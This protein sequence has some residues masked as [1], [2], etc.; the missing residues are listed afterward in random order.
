MRDKSLY[1]YIRRPLTKFGF[2]I[3]NKT[4]SQSISE[5][6]RSLVKKGAAR[7]LERF[8]E[9]DVDVVL[10][11]NETFIRFQESFD[12]VLAPIGEKRIGSTTRIDNK[13]GCTVLPTMD[14]SIIIGVFGGYLMKRWLDYSK[15]LVCL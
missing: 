13:M 9:E 6:W 12:T 7:V 14:M 11:A 3:R 10:A 2:T 8:N 1:T 15:S 5:D 4:V